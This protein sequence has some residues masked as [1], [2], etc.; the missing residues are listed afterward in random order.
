MRDVI[1][2]FEQQQLENKIIIGGAPVTSRYAEEI[3]A[4]GYAADA[5]SA[6]KKAKEILGI[7]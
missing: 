4:S 7:G 3:G 1:N 2:A 5:S 6:V